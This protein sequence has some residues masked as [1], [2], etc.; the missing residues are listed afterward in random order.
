MTFKNFLK[1]GHAPTLFSAFLYFDMSF[2]VWVILG[3]LGVHIS[4]ELGLSPSQKGL[5]VAFPVLSGALIRPLMGLLV[6]RVGA[7]RAGALGQIL[8]MAAL[9][10]A[11]IAGLHTFHQVL[12][13]GVFLGVAGASFAA[14]LPLASRWYPA[15]SQ[16]LALGIAGAGNSGTVLA[17]L[18]APVLANHLGWNGVLG[19]A[20]LPL[21]VTFLAYLLLAKDA[22]GTPP[23]Q[24]F[25]RY[26]AVLKEKDAW[27]FMLFYMVTFGGFVG[28]ASSLVIYFN[29]QYG[30]QPTVAGYLTA[31]IVFFGSMFRPIGGTV[32]DR[33]GGVRALQVLYCVVMLAMTG[34]A[35]TGGVSLIVSLG[36]FVIGMM[37]MGM[38][39]GA[40][41]QLLPQRFQKEIGTLT[42]LVGMAGGIG[43]FYLASSLGLS[44]QWTGDY[45]MG[46]LLYAFMGAVAFGILFRVKLR[47]RATWGAP[48]VARA[49]V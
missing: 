5:M 30:L 28:L 13:L 18:F 46:F 47:W 20:L 7:K 34:V 37:A 8:V 35:M 41:F 42:G 32:A 43:G 48:S 11:W 3:P 31:G 1:A 17:A 14:A 19:L 36:L 45:K 9:A 2:M 10:W 25:S 39:N 44:K 40:V 33:V 12:A 16:G 38:G 22:P 26:F 21:S 24:P 15:E 29:S 27:W 4:K 23:P 6:D 49:R